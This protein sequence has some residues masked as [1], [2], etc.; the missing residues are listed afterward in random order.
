MQKHM[1]YKAWSE[2]HLASWN[3][4]KYSALVREYKRPE[5][6]LMFLSTEPEET[7]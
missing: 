7:W 2:T 4:N 5:T 6:L 3:R 1:K